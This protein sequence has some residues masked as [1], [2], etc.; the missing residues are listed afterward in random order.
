MTKMYAKLSETALGFSSAFPNSYTVEAGFSHIDALLTEQRKRLD[1]GKCGD[2]RLKLTNL[3]PN[4]HEVI[5]SH[6]PYPSH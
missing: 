6:Q 5:K 1:V 3:Q 2:L 4:I